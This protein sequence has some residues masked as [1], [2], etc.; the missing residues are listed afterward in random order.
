MCAQTPHP[1]MRACELNNSN[2]RQANESRSLFQS[3]NRWLNL[4]SIL[5]DGSSSCFSL[6][7][8]RIRGMRVFKDNDYI[9]RSLVPP[10][11]LKLTP[12]RLPNHDSAVPRYGSR[13][14]RRLHGTRNALAL[15]K[16]P[17]TKLIRKQNLYMQTHCHEKYREKS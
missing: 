17:T 1:R 13:L 11:N 15:H 2:M 8:V 7:D 6:R 9:F 5:C 16:L 3:F 4:S 12:T 14:G 10:M